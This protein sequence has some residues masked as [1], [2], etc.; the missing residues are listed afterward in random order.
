M[1][2]EGVQSSVMGRCEKSS[3]GN[4]GSVLVVGM[5]I[6]VPCFQMMGIMLCELLLF[7]ML[8]NACY[9]MLSGPQAGECFRLWK[10]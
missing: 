10:V 4:V 9:V 2:L 8:V 7:T 6:M 3:V 1:T 5:V